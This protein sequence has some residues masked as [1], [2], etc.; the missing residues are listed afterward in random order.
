MGEVAKW[1]GVVWRAFSGISGENWWVCRAGIEEVSLDQ[2]SHDLASGT[3]GFFE[4]FLI[5]SRT[6]RKAL[7]VVGET[8]RLGALLGA[9]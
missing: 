2:R 1:A 9:T 5:S 7:L 4:M 6:A 8:F 3:S